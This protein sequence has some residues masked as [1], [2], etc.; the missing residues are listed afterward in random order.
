MTY[1]EYKHLDNQNRLQLIIEGEHHQKN[2]EKV[3]EIYQRDAV[4]RE[5]L[6]ESYK[7][8]NFAKEQT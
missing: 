8:L 6:N 1:E 3:R 2:M 7:K 4:H 5:I